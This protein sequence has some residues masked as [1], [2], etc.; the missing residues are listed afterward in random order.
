MSKNLTTASLIL[1]IGFVI[2]SFLLGFYFKQSRAADSFVTVKGLSEREVVADRGW[3]AINTS[4]GSNDLEVLKLTMSRQEKIIKDFLISKGLKA[5]EI[6]TDNINFY[7][8]DYKTAVNRFSGN[9]RVAVSSDNVAAVEK[10]AAD[11]TG[12]IEKGVLISGDKWSNGPKYYFTK[13][14]ELKTEM[15]AEAT[16]EAEKAAQEFAKNSG[17]KVGKIRR[18]NQGIFQILPSD[19]SNESSDFYKDKVIRVV[20][21]VDFYLD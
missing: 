12:L 3:M 2:G 4:V 9:L 1:A 13:F 17:A 15:I 19:R 21:T 16:K 20:S 7:T 5:D 10:A 11:R 8:N 14:S 18:A 6:K